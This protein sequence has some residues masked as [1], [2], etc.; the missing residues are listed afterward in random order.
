M[1]LAVAQ[2][3]RRAS[4][5][6]PATTAAPRAAR[7]FASATLHRWGV[8]Y[9]VEQ[10]ELIV[11]ELVTNAFRHGRTA[12]RLVLLSDGACLRI[13]VVDYGEGGAVLRHPGPDDV[14]GRGLLL[15][16]AMTH[17]WGAQREGDEHTVWCEID[18]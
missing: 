17:K 18:L 11:S 5:D 15:V 4:L 3:E 2:G 14:S 13:E 10:A 12:S 7:R 1:E 6:L 16:E 8:P 9:A